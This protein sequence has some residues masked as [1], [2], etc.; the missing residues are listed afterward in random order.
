M[1]RKTKA[2]NVD[3]LASPKKVAGKED[4][5]KKTRMMRVE[6]LQHNAAITDYLS[7]MS[8][9]QSSREAREALDRMYDNLLSDLIQF[10]SSNCPPGKKT[11]KA[12][13]A[14]AAAYQYVIARCQDPEPLKALLDNQ[15][16]PFAKELR[17]E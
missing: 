4:A 14:Y 12:S 17:K 9:K 2:D 11:M 15:L 8:I 13:H 6:K 10:A 5:K 3:P 16:P 7:K 1:G